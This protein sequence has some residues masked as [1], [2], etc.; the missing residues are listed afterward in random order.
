D[1]DG[2]AIWNA[3]PGRQNSK[4]TT[5][6]A[7]DVDFRGMLRCKVDEARLYAIPS[8]DDD[9]NLI[10]TDYGDGDSLNF[11]LAGE[12]LVYTGETLYEQRGGELYTDMLIGAFF[13]DTQMSNLKTSYIDISRHGIEMYSDGYLNLISG[14]KFNMRAGAGSNAIGLSNDHVF[15]YFAWA[16]AENPQEAPFWVKMDGTVRATKLQLNNSNI[17]DFTQM[18]PYADA[19]N[20]SPTYPMTFR[21]FIPAECSGVQSV[22]LTFACEPFRAYSTGAASGGGA[23]SSAGGGGARTSRTGGGATSG[24]TSQ[25]TIGGNSVRSGGG[26]STVQAHTH[27]TDLPTWY[28]PAHAHSTPSHSHILDLPDHAHT[29]PNHTHGITYGIYTGTTATGV[30]V[31][32]DGALVGNFSG[33]TARD[34]TAHLKKSGGK[35]TRDAWHIVTLKPNNLTRI[36]AQA[37]VVAVMGRANNAIF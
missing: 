18:Y 12:D 3:Q 34:I 21:I 11:A 10:M 27:V 20:A 31:K 1:R 17:T 23:T 7:A 16:G 29:V 37:F 4:T 14:S 36:V 2:D 19:E 30:E 6:N 13:L 33:L 22:K 32:V 35:I 15:D 24:Q 8:V 28:V 25:I 9:G 26:S 5:I